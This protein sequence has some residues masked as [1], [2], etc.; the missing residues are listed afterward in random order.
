MECGRR[1]L[2]ADHWAL[3]VC[4]HSAEGYPGP[5]LLTARLD[6]LKSDLFKWQTTWWHY[7]DHKDQYPYAAGSSSVSRWAKGLITQLLLDRTS[8]FFF[9]SGNMVTIVLTFILLLQEVTAPP[10]PVFEDP[11]PQPWCHSDLPLAPNSSLLLL[12][13]N[14]GSKVKTQGFVTIGTVNP[15]A[16]FLYRSQISWYF[17]FSVTYLTLYDPF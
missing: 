14:L 13:G 10:P 11:L 8:F 12:P 3:P 4:L 6:T 1:S 9:S 17:I 5:T 15:L 16:L 2:L 7:W